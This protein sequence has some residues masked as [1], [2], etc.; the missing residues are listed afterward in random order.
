[1][2]WTQHNATQNNQQASE[3]FSFNTFIG[4]II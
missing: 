3:K 1:M 2:A 4:D